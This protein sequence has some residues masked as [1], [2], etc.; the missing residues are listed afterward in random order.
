MAGVASTTLEGWAIPMASSVFDHTYVSSKCGLVWRCWGRSTGGAAICSGIGSSIVA[1]CLSQVNSQAGILYGITG[2]C[3]QTAN[4][5]LHPAGVLVAA[6]GGYATTMIAWGAFGRGPWNQRRTC[7]VGTGGGAG[8]GARQVG[9]SGTDGTSSSSG[10][11]DNA[12]RLSTYSRVVI[13]AKDDK[14]DEEACRLAELSALIEYKLGKP[15]DTPT[16]LKL[17]SI[18]LSFWRY[19]EKL[20]NELSMAK[21][22]EK[23]Y[24]DYFNIAFKDTMTK[25]EHLLGSERFKF[26]FGDAGYRP[27]QMID[28]EIFLNQGSAPADH[29]R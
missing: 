24:L 23:E 29:S 7:Y 16:F 12:A 18:Q 15:L 17:A 1:D 3:Q 26:I 28:P 10:S 20:S 19:Q 13:M 4:R 21:F 27:E 22:G 25:M 2:T 5:I 14:K 9:P 6:A 11:D 8:P